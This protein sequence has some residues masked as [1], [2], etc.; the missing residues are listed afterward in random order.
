MEEGGHHSSV[1]A[2]HLK[3]NRIPIHSAQSLTL[4]GAST[5]HARG[6][7]ASGDRAVVSWPFVVTGAV[8]VS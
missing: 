8:N 2:G 3:L 6:G 7:A 1:Q 4:R 5:F